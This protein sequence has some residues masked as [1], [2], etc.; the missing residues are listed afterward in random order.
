[1]EKPL[2]D[3]NIFQ[4]CSLCDPWIKWPISQL[5]KRIRNMSGIDFARSDL[6]PGL[7]CELVL[8]DEFTFQRPTLEIFPKTRG[9]ALLYNRRYG[10]AS[11]IFKPLPLCRQKFRQNFGLFTDK[12]WNIFQNIYRI[13]SVYSPA[14]VSAPAR[15]STPH[16]TS[17]SDKCSC[18]S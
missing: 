7:L 1:M 8:K 2:S 6:S 13:S 3:P 14:R 10:C 17:N 11:G 18:S 12:W 4:N 5:K 9:G 15:F 16:K